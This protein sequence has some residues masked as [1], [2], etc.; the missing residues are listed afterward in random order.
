MEGREEGGARRRWRRC[1]R[2]ELRGRPGG[3]G[4]GLDREAEAEALGIIRKV[5]GSRSI[6]LSRESL[7]LASFL[8]VLSICLRVTG[9]I[10]PTVEVLCTY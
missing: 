2:Y 5:R 7:G 1:Q 9:I 4:T 6:S 10:L 3:A 8:L